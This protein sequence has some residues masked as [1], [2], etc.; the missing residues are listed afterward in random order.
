MKLRFQESPSFGLRNKIHVL[1]INSNV[2]KEYEAAK[3]DNR[4]RFV[5]DV[6][7]VYT[8]YMNGGT[9]QVFG[10]STGNRIIQAVEAFD[11]VG[12]TKTASVLRRC[13]A[14]FPRGKPSV[15]Q[16][17]R[18]DQMDLIEKKNGSAFTQFDGLMFNEDVH[19]LLLGYW[20][21]HE[22]TMETVPVSRKNQLAVMRLFVDLPL[23]D[24]EDYYNLSS[25]ER[26]VWDICMFEAT[27]NT[28]DQATGFVWAFKNA[29][30]AAVLLG[31]EAVGAQKTARLAKEIYKLYPG[32]RP[33]KEIL[34]RLEQ[35]NDIAAIVRERYGAVTFRN[36]VIC[37]DG[38]EEDLF[39]L[40]LE[41]WRK[42]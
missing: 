15:E 20:R 38:W 29:H 23:E 18:R 31:L 30:D 42:N 19:A 6:F 36:G 35:E 16:E 21:S 41:Y 40:I 34:Q 25:R 12:A 11:A 9:R 1:S 22:P 2:D 28:L 14:L 26:I 24:K 33:A 7:W 8:E 27:A 10:N 4:D 13:C 3:L 32:A 37:Y 17:K 39:G 5:W